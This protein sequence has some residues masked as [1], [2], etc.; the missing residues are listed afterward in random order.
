MF[1]AQIDDRLYDAP[2]VGKGDVELACEV[3]G[4]IRG[5]AQDN[6][7]GIITRVHAGDIPVR[8][9]PNVC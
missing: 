8:T 9:V 6:V 2:P 3:Q 5:S 7:A 4:S 1:H